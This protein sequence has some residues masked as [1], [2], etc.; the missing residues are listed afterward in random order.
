MS[1]FEG[2]RRE[3]C[4]I[5]HDG[6][7]HWATPEGGGLR[8]DDGRSLALE[9][10]RFLPPCRPSKILCVHTNYRSRFFEMTGKTEFPPVPTFFQKPLSALNG[11]GG[12]LVIPEGYR[13]LNYEGELAAI[14]G[15]PMRNV[16]PDEVWEGLAGFAAA[17][18]VGL[19]DMRAADGGSILRVKGCDGFCPVGPSIVW[20]TDVR[21]AVLRTRLNGRLVQEAPLADMM[22]GIDYLVA[23]LARLITLEPGDVIL[24]GTPANSR[25]MSPGD[26]V[27]VDIDGIGCLR[28]V[29]RRAPAPVAELGFQPEDTPEVR[30]IALG[31][32]DRLPEP[33]RPA[34]A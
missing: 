10:V 20:G 31:N 16:R 7:P 6:S 12:E 19:H 24:T 9:A 14:V 13:Y 11:H 8:L 30:Q 32:D 21:S 2:G 26:V 17:N 23:D 28:N 3:R 34:R 27:E 29:V 33:F 15:R 25:P 5:L 4:R 1:V 18:D 22:F